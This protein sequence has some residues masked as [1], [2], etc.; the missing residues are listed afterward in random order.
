M[1]N[2]IVRVVLALCVAAP[3]AHAQDLTI[4]DFTTGKSAVLKYK[5]GATN[6]GTQTGATA[7]LIGGTRTTNFN[8]ATN[9]L[10]QTSTFQFRPDGKHNQSAYI[11]NVAFLVGSREDMVYGYGAPMHADFSSYSGDPNG[12]IRV[13]FLGLTGDLNFN[14][15]LF[16]GTI[17]AQGGCNITANPAPF[18]IELPLSTFVDNGIN[19]ADINLIDVITQSGSQIGGIE[20]AV[21]S[22]E[23]SK[24]PKPGALPCQ[25]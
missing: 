2:N 20:F 6:T 4:D 14:I 11:H 13:N 24:T 16:T 17:Y 21:T 12:L 9:P 7:H 23:V 19:Y 1:K 3:F 8:I 22:I 25:I 10:Q 18:S 5:G 15:E